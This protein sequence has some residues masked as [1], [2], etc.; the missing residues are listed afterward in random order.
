VT[1]AE[2]YAARLDEREQWAHLARS[3]EPNKQSAWRA[4]HEKVFALGGPE[5]AIARS[6]SV[7][8]HIAINDPAAVLADIAAKRVILDLADEADEI[9]RALIDETAHR[10]KPGEVSIGDQIRRALAA[11]FA[12]HPDYNQAWRPEP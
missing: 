4:D 2:F 1:L 6:A 8:P 7:A 9:E 11:P 5:M 10:P 12:S 3:A